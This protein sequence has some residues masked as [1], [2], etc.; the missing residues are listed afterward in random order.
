MAGTGERLGELEA[1]M[2]DLEVETRRTM[3]AVSRDALAAT[4]AHRSNLDLL[5]ALRASQADHS[6][7]LAGHTR[8]LAGHTRTLA[9]HSRAHDEHRARF[10]ALDATLA[11]LAVGMHTI[12]SLLRRALSDD[13]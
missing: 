5:N 1:R 7:T 13:G 2:D 3:A 4:R 6:R 10:D 12:E 8:T 9:E 11:R